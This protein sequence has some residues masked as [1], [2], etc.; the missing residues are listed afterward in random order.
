MAAVAVIS[1]RRFAL[2][3]VREDLGVVLPLEGQWYRSALDPRLALQPVLSGGQLV[4][5]R[6]YQ[7]RHES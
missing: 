3:P 1:R 2:L 4:G 6:E 5:W 7:V